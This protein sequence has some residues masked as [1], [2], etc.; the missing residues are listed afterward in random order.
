MTA[1]AF[2]DVLD[3][4][5]A[6]GWADQVAADSR[7]DDDRFV[8]SDDR[9]ASWA[10]RKRAKAAAAV[11]RVTADVKERKK[12]LDAYQD[13][14]TASA[15]HTVE[16]MDGLLADYHARV[17]AADPDRKTIDLP[18]GRIKSRT[19]QPVAEITDEKPAFAWAMRVAP[20]EA[21][22]YV[23]KFNIR[24]LR[25]LVAVVGDRVVDSETGE[26]VPGLSVKP[27]GTT[28]TV[29]TDGSAT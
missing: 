15:R 29:T 18:E 23:R 14:A 1:E 17:L 24:A 28:F 2:D 20:G 21:A 26:V 22:E 5:G 12:L 10:L 6:P 19:T 8:I 9:A 27:G 16:F 7:A 13:R 4:L 25:K 3:P 11:D